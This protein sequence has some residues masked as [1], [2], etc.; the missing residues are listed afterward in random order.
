MIDPSTPD[1]QPD[2]PDPSAMT[3]AQLE[4]IVAKTRVL[5]RLTAD[6]LHL[7][8]HRRSR[9]PANPAKAMATLNRLDAQLSEMEATL[10][11]DAPRRE[12]VAV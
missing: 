6:Y 11:L 9:G 12:G 1:L 2:V 3:R 4:A 7:L 8:G 10:G 5:T